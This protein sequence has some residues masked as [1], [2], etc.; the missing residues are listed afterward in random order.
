MINMSEDV[1][2][3]F[4]Q[5]QDWFQTSPDEQIPLERWRKNFVSTDSRM[6]I[7]DGVTIVNVV[8]KEIIPVLAAI[9]LSASTQQLA[10][11][12]LHHQVTA[13][14]LARCNYLSAM[15]LYFG[16]P[17]T[18]LSPWNV[19]RRMIEAFCSEPDLT[20][21]FLNDYPLAYKSPELQIAVLLSNQ[22][23]LWPVTKARKFID[24]IDAGTLDAGFV[25]DFLD[26]S[27]LEMAQIDFNDLTDNEILLILER[28]GQLCLEATVE[29]GFTNE[30][31]I[32]LI[33]KPDDKGTIA[34]NR[35]IEAINRVENPTLIQRITQRIAETL[36]MAWNGGTGAEPLLA[37]V[38][39]SLDQAKYGVLTTNMVLKLAILTQ[40]GLKGLVITNHEL[41]NEPCF[42]ALVSAPHNV[43]SQL[44]AEL[45]D[46]DSRAFKTLHFKAISNAFWDGMPTQ[47][48]TIPALQ[49]LL[50][51]TLTALERYRERLDNPSA[52]FK[53]SVHSSEAQNQVRPLVQYAAS[54]IDAD[55]QWMSSLSSATKAFLAGNGFELKKLHG[56]NNKDRGHL[57]EDQLG[58]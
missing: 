36:P 49:D 29:Y 54:R 44:H 3:L 18:N 35:I 25:Y 6:S 17:K 32:D 34:R 16:K 20:K 2:P 1:T 21:H 26:L 30:F 58:L 53:K 28:S 51:H 7:N 38:G 47:D 19:A 56:I 11:I 13:T 23:E 10:A 24:A 5:A 37:E 40:P 52:G 9:S 46:V 31:F 41:L 22:P 12:M 48:I 8:S 4:K 39:Q 27:T 50:T 14:D 33:K 43:L 57:L 45:I 42:D 55:Y 15:Q